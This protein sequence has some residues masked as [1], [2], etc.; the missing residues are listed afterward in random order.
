LNELI[1][2]GG[3]GIDAV[4]KIPRVV[5]VAGGKSIIGVIRAAVRVKLNN[6]LIA[7]DHVASGFLKDE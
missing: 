3:L 7:D 6:V 5:G 4:R 1:Q 2:F